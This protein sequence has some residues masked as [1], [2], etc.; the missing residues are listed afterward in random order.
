MLEYNANSIS[1]S[2]TENDKEDA[3]DVRGE[4]YKENKDIHKQIAGGQTADR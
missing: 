4:Y 2:G 1:N 3:A